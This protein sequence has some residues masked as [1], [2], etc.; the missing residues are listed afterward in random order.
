MAFLERDNNKKVYFE[1]YGKG[2]DAVVLIHGWGAGVRAWDYSLDVLIDAGHRVVAID[3]RACGRSDKDFDD[4]GINAIA[5]DVV[6]LVEKLQLS[7]VVLNGWSLGGAVAVEAATQLQ[8][9]CVGLFLTCAASP[10]YLQK[11]DYTHGGTDDALAETLAALSADR[12]NFLAALS[13]GVCAAEVSPDVVRWMYDMFLES[14]P[15]A[16]K[17]LAELGPLDQREMLAALDIPI[18]STVGAADQVV[19]PEVCRSV[20]NYNASARVVEFAESGHAPFIE[21]SEKYHAELLGFLKNCF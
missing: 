6:A 19:D 1:D 2:A 14:S 10:C 9:R 20:A 15:R 7:R 5:G 17:S 11:S 13:Q 21:E 8:A 18:V 4:V 16:A 12:V 3:H